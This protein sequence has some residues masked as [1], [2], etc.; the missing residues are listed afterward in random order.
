M[1]TQDVARKADGASGAN[2][3]ARPP[4]WLTTKMFCRIRLEML[5]S[6][7]RDANEFAE[8]VRRMRKTGAPAAR[9]A[10]DEARRQSRLT[11]EAYDEHVRDHG[12]CAL[13]GGDLSETPYV[14]VSQ[15]DG[16]LPSSRQAPSI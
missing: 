16:P 8:A 7:V 11:H 3:V 4:P 14:G 9:A 15:I 6:R 10:C 1:R 13:E 12:C 5:N 2:M